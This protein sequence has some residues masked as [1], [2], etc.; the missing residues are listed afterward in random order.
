MIQ[1]LGHI[2][3]KP[4]HEF[5]TEPEEHTKMNRWEKMEFLEETT[6][7]ETHTKTILNELVAWMGDDDFNRFYDHFCS[8]W[9]ICR[10]NTE[11][12]ETYGK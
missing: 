12:N 4:A 7:V 3:E 1:D 5:E 2:D 11:L 6:P 8:N 10:S 9:D